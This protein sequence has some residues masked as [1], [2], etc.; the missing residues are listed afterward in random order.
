M[1][2]SETEDGKFGLG[3]HAPRGAIPGSNHLG[4][5]VAGEDIPA[6]TQIRFTMTAEASLRHVDGP[7]T[8]SNR[9]A[10]ACKASSRIQCLGAT[11]L[12]SF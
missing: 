4:V 3:N 6:F 2:A 8:L 11:T 7:F 5:Q 10:P 9:R 1:D 12:D